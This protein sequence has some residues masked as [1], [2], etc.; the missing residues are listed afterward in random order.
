MKTEILFPEVANLC[1]DLMNVTYLRQCCP[2]MEVV[3]RTASSATYC[4]LNCSKRSDRSCLMS[5]IIPFC[6]WKRFPRDAPFQR[7]FHAKHYSIHA[8]PCQF[9][10]PLR[11][12]KTCGKMNA[13]NSI[14]KK[15]AVLC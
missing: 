3:V 15:G 12:G 11:A 9:A 10:P 7:F 6:V 4:F 5:L 1:G 13:E 8:E 14:F 2:K